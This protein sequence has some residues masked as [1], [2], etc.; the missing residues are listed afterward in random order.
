MRKDLI[1]RQSEISEW[2]KENRTKAFICRQLDCKWSTLQRA[3][4]ALKIEYIGN[5]GARGQKISKSKKTALEY[6]KSTCVRSHTLKIKLL[7]DKVFEYRC[8]ICNNDTWME[9]PIPL[10]LD[11]IDGNHFNN[12]FAN[13][14]LV[15]PNC[16][17]MQ[18]TNSGKNK[19]LKRVSRELVY[20]S[21]LE[22]D[23]CGFESHL[24][25]QI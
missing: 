5:Q 18:P 19:K 16:H 15:C 9:K 14:R 1:E 17:A 24:T 21:G 20:R 25:H 23:V 2:I 6:S 10:E 22:P 13:L 4:K 12:D 8:Q 7:E 3:L 11:H